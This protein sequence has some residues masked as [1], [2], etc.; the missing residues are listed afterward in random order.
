MLIVPETAVIILTAH[1]SLESAIAAIREGV[2]GYLLKPVGPGE[3]RQAVQEALAQRERLARPKEVDEE[4]HLL[5]EGPFSVDPKKHLAT[6]DGRPLDL[7]PSEF[8]LLLCLMQNAHRVVSPR[9]LVQAVRGYESEYEWEA[10][11]TIKWYIHRL[12]RKVEPDPS[13]PRHILNV[14]GVGYT[15]EE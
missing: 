12:R 9:E 7:T 10:R 11:E 13:S 3:V 6:L 15:F 1:G 5:Q 2:D 8:K 14:R 4:E